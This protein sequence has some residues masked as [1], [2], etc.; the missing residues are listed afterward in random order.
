[1]QRSP[2]RPAPAATFSDIFAADAYVYAL[3]YEKDGVVCYYMTDISGLGGC[4]AW[5]IDY[6]SNMVDVAVTRSIG[7]CI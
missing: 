4:E 2:Y 3:D 1:M 7:S 6:D 5:P